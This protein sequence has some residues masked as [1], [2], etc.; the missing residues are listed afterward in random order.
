MIN[1]GQR[2]KKS[3]DDRTCAKKNLNKNNRNDN[4]GERGRAPS[5]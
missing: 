2:E 3:A 1:N 4:G 5:V